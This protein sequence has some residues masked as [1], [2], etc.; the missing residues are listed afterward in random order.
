M[1]PKRISRKTRQQA[2]WICDVAASGGVWT[3]SWLTCV[4]YYSVI[5]AS[6]GKVDAEATS[7]AMR[8]WG[9]ALKGGRWTRAVD[10]EAAQL[11]REG[12]LPK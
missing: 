6:I 4:P 11:I 12:W 5:A 2:A 3:E 7:L 1:K 10:A 8:A 9:F